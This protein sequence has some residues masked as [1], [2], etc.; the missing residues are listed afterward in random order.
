[1]DQDII[2]KNAPNRIKV[3]IY[4]LGPPSCRRGWGVPLLSEIILNGKGL[5]PY[6]RG[7]HKSLLLNPNMT[8]QQIAE[9][10][11]YSQAKIS[12]Y[13]KELL[14][15]IADIAKIVPEEL[16]AADLDFLI[17]YRH[18]QRRPLQCPQSQQERPQAIYF[19]GAIKY[20]ITSQGAQKSR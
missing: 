7:I 19:E 10:N 11:G 16:Q 9:Q 5:H 6:G 14:S 2:T 12:G 15:K 3:L 13:Q 1:M 20:T 8:Q 17:D 18:P 4:P